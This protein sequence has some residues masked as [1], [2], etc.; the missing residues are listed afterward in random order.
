MKSNSITLTGIVKPGH[1]VASGNAQNSP[2]ERGTLEMQL[3]FFQ[4]L[5]LDLSGFYVMCIFKAVVD[6]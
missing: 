2:Y 5:G 3:P 6:R 1:Q 4:K